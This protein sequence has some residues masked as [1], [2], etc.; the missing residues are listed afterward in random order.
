MVSTKEQGKGKTWRQWLLGQGRHLVGDLWLG[1]K[2]TV[3]NGGHQ[4]HVLEPDQ[5]ELEIY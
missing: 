4:G 2:I 3:N 1:Y 5:W